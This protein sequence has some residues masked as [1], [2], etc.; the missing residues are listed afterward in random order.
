M[1]QRF[2][3]FASESQAEAYENVCNILKD[4][5]KKGTSKPGGKHDQIPNDPGPPNATTMGWD[6]RWS[7]P[8]LNN[9]GDTWGVIAIDPATCTADELARLSGGQL[10]TLQSTW[11][12]SIEIDPALWF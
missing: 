12:T 1:S 5:P 4:L 3:A 6:K 8:V 9:A 11:S 2:A 10:N 7:K